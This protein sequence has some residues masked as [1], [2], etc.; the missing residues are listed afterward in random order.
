ML[1]KVYWDACILGSAVSIGIRNSNHKFKT[2][3]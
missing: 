1:D 2:K 3:F